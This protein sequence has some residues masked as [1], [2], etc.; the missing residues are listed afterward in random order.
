MTELTRRSLLR[1]CAGVACAPALLQACA[2]RESEALAIAVQAPVEGL[3][4]VSTPRVPEL[5][6]AGGSLILHPEGNDL[7]GRPLSLL[8]A[9]TSSQGLK[10][11]DAYCP[12]AGCEVAWADH[13]DEVVCPCHQSRFSVDGAVKQPPARQGLDSYSAKLSADNQTLIVDL[14][15]SAGVFPALQNGYVTFLIK[16][17]PDLLLLGGSVTGRAPGVPFPLVLLR[18]S[19]A[20]VLAFDARCPHLGCSVE[21]AQKL[22]ICPCHGSLFGLDGSVKQGPAAKPLV[23]LSA[24]FDGQTV[25]VKIA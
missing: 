18:S 5:L 24:T 23:A 14:S 20:E 11:W 21:G 19:P 8:V 6:K 12:H 9:N 7:F 4:S 3:V 13:D 16:S 1:V 10:A 22:L 17:V 25:S 15:G 2:P